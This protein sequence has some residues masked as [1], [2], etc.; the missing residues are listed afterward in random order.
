MK[1]QLQQMNPQKQI[2]SSQTQ[3]KAVTTIRRQ[4]KK[5]KAP[6]SYSKSVFNLKRKTPHHY[7]EPHNFKV[8]VAIKSVLIAVTT[9][10]G[11]QVNIL[12]HHIVKQLNLQ[13]ERSLMKICP[14]G[15]RPFS[16]KGQFPLEIP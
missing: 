8:Q 6:K 3:Q 7:W 16:M 15:S 1:H 13:I 11:A 5:K 2:K 10:T 12:P 14:Y 9:D 4:I